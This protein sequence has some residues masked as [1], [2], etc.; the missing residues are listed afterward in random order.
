MSLRLGRVAATHPEDNSVDLV[1]IDDGSRL[2]GVQVLAGSATTNSGTHDLPSVSKPASGDQW[3]LTERTDRDMTAV[4]GFIGRAPVVVGFLFPQ[5]SQMLFKD[6]NRRVMR[7]ASDVYTS[8]DGQGNTE[9]Y[10]PSGTYLRIGATPD[11]EDLT[12][13]DVDGNWAI[14]KNTSSAV[15]VRLRVANAGVE[16]A[17]VTIDPSGNVTV[18]N[19]GN[20]SIE[21]DGNASLQADGTMALASGG[22]MSITAPTLNIAANTVIT[23]SM[24]NNGKDVGSGH[25]HLNSGGPNLGGP[26]Q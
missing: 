19:K 3:S 6:A 12:G 24:T 22:T 7:H 26:P 2:A 21:T 18:T 17:V 13:K 4:V 15:N 14:S 20:L 23:G 25:Q 1:M 5:V 8:I 16:K 11:H 10:H 9:L